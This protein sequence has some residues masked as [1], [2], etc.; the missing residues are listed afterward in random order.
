MAKKKLQNTT[1]LEVLWN[2][3]DSKYE[4]ERDAI[5]GEILFKE[6]GDTNFTVMEDKHLDAITVIASFEGYKNA[7]KKRIKMLLNS[8][9]V[10]E[11]NYIHDYF[12]SIK[13]LH[14]NDAI[15]KL[16]SCIQCTNQL[17][18]EKYL[19]KWLT[20]CVANVHIPKGCQNQMCLVLTGG[21]GAG[22][23]TFYQY[24]IPAHLDKFMFTGEL[25]LM[26]K[27][28]CDWKLVEY[29]LVNIEEQIKSLNHTDAN[30][31][32]N[33]ITLPDVKGRKPYGMMES[34]GN[35]IGC[36]MASTND[37]D[38]L[39]DATG[40]RRYPSFKVISI[41]EPAYRKININTVW[42]EAQRFFLDKSFKY[43]VTPEDTKELEENNKSFS[44][45][46]QEHELIE[47]YFL[48]EPDKKKCTHAI[49]T[50][51]IYSFLVSD[52]HKLESDLFSTK[53]WFLKVKYSGD[54]L[55]LIDQYRIK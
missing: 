40:S 23:S 24:L 20:A 4:F 21:Q 44:Y 32:K 50:T 25:D 28:D 37:E 53:C 45:V 38:F 13:S 46:S 12:K 1:Q 43:W 18:W 39:F 7:E 41:N 10:T 5:K 17:L 8:H 27:K 30:R 47:H 16:A 55:K 22:K 49:K 29:W 2:W 51:F 54:S 14:C 48:Q 52:N 6:I 19:I 26:N 11:K 36:F 9:L 15:K 34:R 31:M 33:L 35:R 3:L 42:A